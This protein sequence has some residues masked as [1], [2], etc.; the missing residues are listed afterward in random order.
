MLLA[1]D[2]AALDHHEGT[3]TLISNAVNW[4]DSPERVDA[5][6]DAAVASLDAMTRGL[7]TAA[8]PTTAVYDRPKPQYLRRRSPEEHTAAI[9]VA[10]E[11]IR[12]GEAF[13]VVLSQRF[14]MTT[15]ADPLDV[16]RVLRAT[17]PSPYM[18]LLRLDG[19]DIVGSS[20]ESLVTVRDRQ[21]TT[22]PI[23]GTRWRGVDP[24]ED[25]LL[26]KDLLAD[27]KERAEHVMLVDL[28]RNDLGRVCK[29]GSVHVVDFFRVERYSHVMHIV[30]TVTGELADGKTAYDAVAA[31]FPAGTLSGAPKPR[32]MEL[33]EELEPTRR[34]LYG[35][36]VGYLDFGGDADTAIAIRTALMRDGT[37][38][39]QAGGGIVADSNPLA[40]DDEC[41]N[42]AGAVLAA[43][44]TAQTMRPAANG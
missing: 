20:P 28:G 12:A 7:Q 34:G 35:G 25:A 2:L 3:I 40:E 39:V 19:F 41:V 9:N 14:E 24:D 33:I 13:Q 16:Y 42:K 32:A 21:A 22:H 29:P 8:P 5:A 31:C 11:A 44:A 36:V 38:Y 15:D 6:Y 18:Y 26:E 43:I 10:K 17:N 4:D 23:A 27:E 1:I 37:A 30:S